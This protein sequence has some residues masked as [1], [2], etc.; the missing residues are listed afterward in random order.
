MKINV[1]DL[2][3]GCGGLTDGFLQTDSFNTLASI[4][5]ELSTVNTLKN[6][7]VT[8]YKY[9]KKDAEKKVLYFD[10]QRIEEL[11]NGYND[12]KYGKS[13]GFKKIIGNQ[14]VDLIIG[15]PPCQAYSIAGRVRCANGMKDD[16]RNFLF[17]SYIN[18][19]SE[20][21]PKFFIF[22]NVEGILS[23]KPGDIP[24]TERIKESFEKIGYF[25]PENLRDTA[26]FD[27]SYYGIPQKRKR[28]II[29]GVR[30]DIGKDKIDIFYKNLKSKRKR[31]T[32]KSN[33]AFSKL[34]KLFPLKNSKNKRISHA[35]KKEHDFKNHEPRFHN[36]R[37]I[38]IFYILTKDIEDG[39]FKYT[40]TEALKMLY[41]KQTGKK[42]NFHKY[43]VIRRDEPSNTIPAHLY[44]D[45]LRH[46][47]PD[48]EQSRTITVREA[49]KLQSF[50]DDFEF[51]G[52]KGDQYKMVGNAV[53][54]KFAKQIAES[55][56]PFFKTK[57]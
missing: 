32:T 12:K 42:S 13:E 35:P 1:I 40:S 19:V 23:A 9:S 10:I 39:T 20:F 54:P 45:G 22:E 43:N 34:P 21:K 6:R 36:E 14:K 5:W 52:S 55:I 3:A 2:F 46:I 25:I 56:I 11:L 44:K 47:H 38:R 26:L 37:D 53:P 24:I 49:A 31:N 30:N 28:I 8:K 15:G 16:Y 33:T 7:L 48:S 29:F 57:I 4:D 17:E 27:L 50:D 18:V 41:E 51:L